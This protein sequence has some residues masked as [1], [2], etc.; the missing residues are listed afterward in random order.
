M[1]HIFLVSAMLIATLFCDDYD[2]D[3]DA[4]EQKPY[5]YNGYIKTENKNEKYLHLETLL[6]VSYNYEFLKLNSSLSFD[7]EYIKDKTSDEKFSID[8]L[9]VD[10]KLNQNHT[11]S[12]GKE[13]LK[14]G[15]GYF[16]NPIAFFDRAKDPSDPTLSREGFVMTKYNY[17][18]SLNTNLK[19]I[20]F[21]A[22]YL[23]SN[24]S[25]ND[26][27][28]NKDANN[29]ALKLYLLLYDTDI[30]II[31]NYSD[32]GYEKMGID[33][34]KNLQTNFEIHGEYAKTTSG[35]F[36]YLFGIRYLTDSELTIISEYLYNSKQT[37]PF[38]GKD[39][40]LNLFTQKEPFDILYSTI[41]YKNIS[42]LQDASMQ[43]KIGFSYSFINDVEL[44]ISYNINSG[45]A[46]SEYGSKG[47]K[48]FVWVK[49]VHSF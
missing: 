9:F 31:Y 22:V 48:S 17:N 34:S 3:M 25:L 23:P 15:K 11:L 2:F 28:L 7:Y 8:E 5:S 47:L 37:L 4:I 10:A 44:D 46:K 16:F 1:K 6:D 40:L 13:S 29:I 41:Y 36:N 35:D 33:F 20:S 45:D 30:D 32:N 49:V 38:L 18:K 42:N 26:E 39:Y 19:N 21:D 43:N 12:V 27:F 24:H 14:W